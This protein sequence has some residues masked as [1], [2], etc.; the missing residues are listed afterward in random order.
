[1][2]ISHVSVTVHISQHFGSQFYKH[3]EV[4]YF[5]VQNVV[6]W[7][8]AARG[9]S[10]QAPTIVHRGASDDPFDVVRGAIL[11]KVCWC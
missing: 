7:V 3:S 5:T 10:L 1:M 9:T 2:S 6:L 4:S 8:T 11:F